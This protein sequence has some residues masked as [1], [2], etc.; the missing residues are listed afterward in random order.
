MRWDEITISN[1]DTGDQE[2]FKT[3]AEAKKQAKK[4]NYTPVYI[5]LYDEFG[6]VDDIRINN[7][8]RRLLK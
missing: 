5:D 1:P 7:K 8:G 3:I 6:I 2:T 4:E